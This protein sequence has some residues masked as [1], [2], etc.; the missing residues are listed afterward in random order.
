MQGGRARARARARTPS[1]RPLRVAHPLPRRSRPTQLAPE[2][3]KAA[4]ILAKDGLKIAKV[5]ATVAKD[6]ATTYAIQGVSSRARARA[7]ARARTLLPLAA[8]L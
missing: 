7:R 4:G 1:R 6:L 8:W 5:D 3:A 2:Y